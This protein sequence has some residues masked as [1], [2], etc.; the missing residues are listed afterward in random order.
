MTNK[1]KIEVLEKEVQRLKDI[2][3]ALYKMSGLFIERGKYVAVALEDLNKRDNLS[4]K[5]MDYIEEDV[6]NLMEESLN[7]NNNN[8]WR[9]L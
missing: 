5:R 6:L 7:N 2:T 1:T 4:N 8:E 3:M 9:P